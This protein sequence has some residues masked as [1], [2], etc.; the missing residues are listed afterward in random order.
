MKMLEDREL[1]PLL[2]GEKS[3]E[4]RRKELLNILATYE[5]GFTPE[6]PKVWNVDLIEESKIAFAG[7]ALQQRFQ[8]N[9]MTPGGMH[10]FHFYLLIPYGVEK[11]PTFLHINFRKDIPDRHQPTE[12]ILDRGYAICTIA[13]K[14]VVPDTI[15]SDFTK[16]MAGMYVKNNERKKDEWGKIGMWAFAASLVIDYLET[17][18][19]INSKE[20]TVIGHS[21]L[22]KTALWCGAQD[23]RVYCTISNCS[24]YGG[25]AIA[26]Y[27]TGESIA[28]F[29]K[30]GSKD[31]MCPAFTDYLCRENEK[32][33]DQHFLL[34]CI[35]PRY[36]CVGSAEEDWGADPES[37]FLSCV[38][39]SEAYE[40]YG[41]K[42]LVYNKETMPEPGTNL[43]DGEIGYHIRKGRHF[44]SREDWNCYM[45]FLDKKRNEK[46]EK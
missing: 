41:L 34:A 25:A 39:A 26:K 19:E 21:R 16:G 12:E 8:M 24:G 20:I 17:R 29:D 37:E 18:P 2:D 1:L 13:Y 45:D 5:Y 4:E 30:Y 44:L 38:A 43:I 11:A 7:K 46:K 28:M 14:D 9:Y 31:W 3:W 42:G 15:D 10:F 32:P 35:A 36:L 6:R 23:E 27:G 40:Q 33:Y 22:G